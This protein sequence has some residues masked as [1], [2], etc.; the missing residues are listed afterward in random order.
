MLL[1]G[2]PALGDVAVVDDDSLDTWL[3]EEIRENAL[4]LAPGSIRSQQTHLKG[5]RLLRLPEG[6]VQTL[7]GDRPFIGMDRG[8]DIEFGSL[9]KGVSRGASDRRTEIDGLQIG[10]D[11]SDLFSAVCDERL[12]TLEA[13]AECI[14][15]A[16]TLGDV[17]GGALVTEDVPVAIA[18][19]LCIDREPANAAVFLLDRYLEVPHDASQFEQLA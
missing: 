1:L 4:D 5:H 12:E 15:S 2:L 11:H 3:L 7:I 8:Q 16:S 9:L 13:G 18:D 17:R 14:L 6:F 10:I 19:G